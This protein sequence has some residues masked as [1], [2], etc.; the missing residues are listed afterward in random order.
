MNCGLHG[1]KPPP[2]FTPMEQGPP[3]CNLH[4]LPTE[5]FLNY[6]YLRCFPKCFQFQLEYLFV[7]KISQLFFLS[8]ALLI[9]VVL[10][11]I[12][13]VGAYSFLPW[14]LCKYSYRTLNCHGLRQL[15][16]FSIPCK[17]SNT[18]CILSVHKKATN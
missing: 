4:I 17:I 11:K 2:S 7:F 13:R 12:V 15:N 8:L 18:F 3:T 16:P 1:N 10:I 14:T 9:K 6:T 5:S